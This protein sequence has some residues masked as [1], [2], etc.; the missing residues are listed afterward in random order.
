VANKVIDVM[1]RK[2]ERLCDH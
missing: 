1:K 2:K